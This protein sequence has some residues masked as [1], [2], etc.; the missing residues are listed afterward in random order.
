MHNALLDTMKATGDAV[1]QLGISIESKGLPW[2]PVLQSPGFAQRQSLRADR[3]NINGKNTVLLDQNGYLPTIQDGFQSEEMQPLGSTQGGAHRQEQPPPLPSPL[4]VPHTEGAMQLDVSPPLNSK[5]DAHLQE[6]LQP[7]LPLPLDASQT[8]RAM[9]LDVNPNPP[10][11]SL[12]PTTGGLSLPAEGQ[13][14]LPSPQPVHAPQ[15]VNPQLNTNGA[16]MRAEGCNPIN[17]QPPQIPQVTDSQTNTHGITPLAEGHNPSQNAQPHQIPQVTDSQT[18]THG[19]T[20]IP[21]GLNPSPNTQPQ[22]IPQVTDSQTNTHG[23]TPIAQGHN[24]SPN[25]QPPQIPQVTHSQTNTHGITPLAEGHN[26]SPNAQPHQ[27]AQV[28]TSQPSTDGIQI[29]PANESPSPN[30]P[31]FTWQ[32]FEPRSLELSPFLLQSKHTVLGR[33]SRDP[34]LPASNLK[35]P[36][37]ACSAEPQPPPKDPVP[38]LINISEV[39]TML[40]VRDKR[41]REDLLGEFRLL[42]AQK[43]N[44]R[45]STASTPSPGLQKFSH[46]SSIASAS[47]SGSTAA[48][49]LTEEKILELITPLLLRGECVFY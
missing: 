25:T 39:L 27:M 5:G 43:S 7:P 18:N 32:P 45:S 19:I 49:T 33:R 23:I 22:Q 36:R 20:P 1:K 13:N 35:R 12:Q 30:P 14:P 38:T 28:M 3:S 21:Q 4:N 15:P 10:M 37:R 9:Q 17:T 26:S 29:P 6:Q 46:Q 41:N 40:E 11:T 16:P 48:V 44:D 31:A 47:I 24:P 8:E 34:S 2:I 42:M